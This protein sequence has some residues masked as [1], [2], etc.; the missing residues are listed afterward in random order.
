[1]APADGISDFFASAPSA[2][3]LFGQP[4]ARVALDA[5]GQA[6]ARIRLIHVRGESRLVALVSP[7]ICR[8]ANREQLLVEAVARLVQAS[9]A[10]VAKGH[11]LPYPQFYSI[12]PRLVAVDARELVSLRAVA[13]PFRRP[14]ATACARGSSAQAGS[15]GTTS[16]PP[17]ATSRPTLEPPP[18]SARHSA[19]PRQPSR[20]W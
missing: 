10:C 18:A 9:P 11:F 7:R 20:R 5:G 14:R 1:L 3:P 6:E 16:S 19:A 12:H 8:F 15:T 2:R 17:T 13:R 4:T